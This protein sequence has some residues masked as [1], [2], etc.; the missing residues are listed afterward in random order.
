MLNLFG[1]KVHPHGVA[2]HFP[3]ALYPTAALLFTLGLFFPQ[4]YFE[5]SSYYVLVV[6]APITPLAYATGY[7]YWRTKYKGYNTPLFDKKRYLGAVLWSLGFILVAVRGLN[8]VIAYAPGIKSWLYMGCIYLAALLPLPL[9]Y[10]GGKLV[11][12]DE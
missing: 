9:G 8:P 4:Q 7:Y 11:F 5:I 3:A 12:K 2:V 10:L 1:Y 6:A